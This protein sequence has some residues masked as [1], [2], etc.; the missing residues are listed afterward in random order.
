MIRKLRYFATVLAL[1]GFIGSCS[2]ILSS[3]QEGAK[4]PPGKEKERKNG[5]ENHPGKAKQHKHESG[6]S[7]LG[8]GIKQNGHHKLESHGKFSASV[9]VSGGKIAGVQVKHDDL[10]DVPVTK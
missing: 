8:N 4:G 1:I 2:S 5:S 10:G 7:L 6:K 3:P 9:D